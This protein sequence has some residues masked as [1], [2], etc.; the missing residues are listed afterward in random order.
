MAVYGPP[1][2]EELYHWKYI[3][4]YKKNGKWRYVYPNDALGLKEAISTKITGSAYD[5]HAD[6]IRESI[7]N[8]QSAHNSAKTKETRQ[9]ISNAISKLSSTRD[10]IDKQKNKTLDGLL[11]TNLGDI[12]NWIK[13]KN[14]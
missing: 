10:F 8:L 5:Q 3:R 14:K 13:K 6:E 2:N 9:T 1:N 12:I 11:D 7:S 4:K